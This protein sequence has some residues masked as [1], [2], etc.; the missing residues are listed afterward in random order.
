M[1]IFAII[2]SL[3]LSGSSVSAQGLSV[4]DELSP[5][6]FAGM[7]WVI[8]PRPKGGGSSKMQSHSGISVRVISSG[9]EGALAGAVGATR[10][11]DGTY[12]C[13][14]GIAYNRKD[15]SYMVTYD[16]CKKNP[17]A[18]FGGRAR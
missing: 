17:L 9:R 8:G 15:E 2:A 18:S 12:G 11:F 13:D 4:A 3:I 5:R 6:F 1:R 14:A 7:S 16:F 10:Y